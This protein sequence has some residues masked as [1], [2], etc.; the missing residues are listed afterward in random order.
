VTRDARLIESASDTAYW[1][2]YH[3]ALESERADALFQDP[4]ARTLAGE[5]GRQIAEGMPTLPGAHPGARGLTWA[6]AVRTRVF[7]ELITESIAETSADAVLN[8]AAGLDT[9]PY[10]IPLP[11]HLTWI[12]ADRQALLTK[13]AE[14]L[15]TAQ[16]ACRIERIAVDL[17]DAASRQSLFEALAARFAR[18]VLITE[19]LLVYLGT[20][21]V[22]VLTTELHRCVPVQR[23]V[24]EMITPET[25]R[26]QMNAWGRVL[27]PAGAEWNFAPSEGFDF[28]L[29]RG[30]H[31][32]SCRS[33]ILE[34][35]RLQRAEMRHAAL[36]RILSRISSTFRRQ[37]ENAARYG[38]LARAAEEPRLC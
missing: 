22:E 27:A 28:F 1:V 24:L 29:R 20:P 18:I 11:Q 16:P 7:D 38:V 8:L 31:L 34:A 30:W 13:K 36:L 17:A 25:Q 10:R 35:R 12:E 14:L 9:R 33:C 6:L 21:L 4:F 19:G 3:R 32:H 5:R 2:A 23:W 26:Q 37:L 15:Q